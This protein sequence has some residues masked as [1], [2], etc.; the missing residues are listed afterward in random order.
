MPHKTKDNYVSRDDAANELSR[1]AEMIRRGDPE[2]DVAFSVQFWF[3]RRKPEI[4]EGTK[5]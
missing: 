2:T 3:R 5:Q 1:I 4:G